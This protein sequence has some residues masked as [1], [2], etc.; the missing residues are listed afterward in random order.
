MPG[1]ASDTIGHAARDHGVH[2]AVRAAERAGGALY[3]T[4]LFVGSG[5]SLLVNHREFM[6]TTMEW[7]VWGQAQCL[8]L[9][10][11]L[12]GRSLKGIRAR[13]RVDTPGRREPGSDLMGERY[14]PAADYYAREGHEWCT[15]PSP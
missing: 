6:R 12:S 3:C 9:R 15:A 13:R 8:Q 11:I 10:A 5:G 2:L 1:P 7:L 14:V 4:A